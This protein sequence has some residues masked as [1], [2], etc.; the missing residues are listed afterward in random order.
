MGNSQF[1]LLIF[2]LDMHWNGRWLRLCVSS[3]EE[4]SLL[5]QV[6]V[7]FSFVV[8]S[9]T[10]DPSVRVPKLVIQIVITLILNCITITFNFTF[11]N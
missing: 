2:K 8:G 6:A 10:A 5:W 1:Y 4:L 9:P 3:L 7:P 11:S